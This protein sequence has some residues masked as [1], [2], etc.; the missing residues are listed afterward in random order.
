MAK[1]TYNNAVHVTTGLTL[2]KVLMEYDP[3]FDVELFREP[4]EVSQNI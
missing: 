3:D 2:I 4:K 1:Y